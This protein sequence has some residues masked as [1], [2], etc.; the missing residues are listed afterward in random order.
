MRPAEVVVLVVGLD[1]LV[2][3]GCRLLESVGHVA[4][5]A[6]EKGGDAHEVPHVGRGVVQAQEAALGVAVVVQVVEVHGVQEAIRPRAAE[7]REQAEAPG[8]SAG[9]EAT[10]VGRVAGRPPV[11]VG[12]PGMGETRLRDHVHDRADLVAVL[13]GHVAVDHLHR[14]GDAGVD[15]VREGDAGLVGNGLAVDDELSLAVRA[16]EVVAPVLV[17]RETGGGGDQLLHGPR[18]DRRRGAEDVGLVDVH[19]RH[20]GVRLEL[21][22]GL[23]GGHGHRLLHSS[24]LEGDRDL[25]RSGRPDVDR[26][27]DRLEALDLDVDL[28]GVEGHVEELVRAGR[29][30]GGLRLE[31]GHVVSELE[32]RAGHG[33]PVGRENASANGAGGGGCVTSEQ[34]ART[35]RRRR[36]RND[37]K[38]IPRLHDSSV[39][40]E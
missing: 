24:Q 5:R 33:A 14:L 25:E 31:A 17:L 9:G 3:P 11:D 38:W 35:G 23:L 15:R 32:R 26:P 12:V 6:A 29:V 39:S 27:V 8:A 7:R 13:G 4:L 22:R 16:L 1:E 2:L 18:G 36:L 10:L 34:R 40:D 19:V 37:G 20:R 28:V 21:R 30:G